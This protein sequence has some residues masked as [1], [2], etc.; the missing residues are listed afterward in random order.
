MK[1]AQHRLLFHS[2]EIA[3]RQGSCGS[4]AQELTGQRSLAKEVFLTHNADGR[5]L[6]GL[7][8]YGEAHFAFLHIENGVCLVSL[9]EYRLFFRDLNNL[10]AFANRREEGVRVEVARILNSDSGHV[11]RSLSLEVRG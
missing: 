1:R 7:G 5:F 4:H 10:S 8:N 2:Q 9:R 11:L 6:S 3:I